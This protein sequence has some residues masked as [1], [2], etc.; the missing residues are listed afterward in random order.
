VGDERVDTV[1]PC[2]VTWTKES[3]IAKG[4]LT[5]NRDYDLFPV[6]KIVNRP[7]RTDAQTEIT[8]R[9]HRPLHLH[10]WRDPNW[11]DFITRGAPISL[12]L[13]HIFPVCVSLGPTT[14]TLHN[15]YYLLYFP[16]GDYCGHKMKPH[17][18]NTHIRTHFSIMASIAGG[19]SSSSST[20]GAGIGAGGGAG[21][22]SRRWCAFLLANDEESFDVVDNKGTIRRID[23]TLSALRQGFWR[24]PHESGADSSAAT[25]CRHSH[26]QLDIYVII[27]SATGNCGTTATRDLRVYYEWAVTRG[28][29]VKNL[30]F[31]HS[32]HSSFAAWI[33]H[34]VIAKYLSFHET[35]PYEGFVIVKAVADGQ[36]RHRSMTESFGR[37]FGTP[38]GTVLQVTIDDTHTMPVA[39]S[40]PTSLLPAVSVLCTGSATGVSNFAQ[41]GDTLRSTLDLAVDTGS[42]AHGEDDSTTTAHPAAA[43]TTSLL[44]TVSTVC[45]ARIGFLGNPSDGFYGQT[46]SF[47]LNNFA[48]S[49]TIEERDAT[50]Q[51]NVV[52][53]V[54]HPV[55]DTTEFEGLDGLHISTENKVRRGRQIDDY[56]A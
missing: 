28:I 7:N 44:K 29:N 10:V 25:S 55:Q 8:V 48:A 41:F 31:E 42:P 45:P 5:D 13:S 51:T 39:I 35:Q 24:H 20:A 12:H 15:S 37:S 1:E 52:E 14:V 30:V 49:V 11:S 3:A 17:T 34:K 40:V 9:T 16:V 23:F 33:N 6:D 46:V 47:L 56:V 22:E 4:S 32:E 38:M 2:A 26:H 18:H 36:Q 54:P 19:N 50:L 43:T 53:I 21:A 27:Q